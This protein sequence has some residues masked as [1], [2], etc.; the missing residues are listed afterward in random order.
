MILLLTITLFF[1]ASLLFLV[2]PM[3][4]KMILP[5]LGGAPAVWNTCV[6]FFQATSRLSQQ[7]AAY[8]ELH[9]A[10]E[11]ELATAYHEIEQCALELGTAIGPEL[12]KA[13]ALMARKDWL[14]ESGA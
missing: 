4:A 2:Q 1:S 6:L 11:P 10:N 12:L 13:A 14:P 8:S 5:V 7:V 9:V 3:F